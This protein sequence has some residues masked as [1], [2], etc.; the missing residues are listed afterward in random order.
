MKKKADHEQKYPTA[1]EREPSACTRGG[2]KVPVRGPYWEGMNSRDE[3]DEVSRQPV[4]RMITRGF[5][6]LD[7]SDY[8]D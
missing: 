6:M 2:A 1:D 7:D 3:T 4:G 5:Q 8:E